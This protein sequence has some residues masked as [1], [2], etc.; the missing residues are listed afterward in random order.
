MGVIGIPEREEGEEGAE[1]FE[2]T[3][4]ENFPKLIT[5]MKP[6]TQEA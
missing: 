5:D 4:A 2:V 1:V 6:Q 3:V